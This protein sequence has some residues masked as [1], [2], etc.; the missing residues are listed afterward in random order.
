[1]R[2]F[3][4]HFWHSGKSDKARGAD[5]QWPRTRGRGSEGCQGELS[6]RSTGDSDQRCQPGSH[7]ETPHRRIIHLLHGKYLCSVTQLT[8]QKVFSC[9]LRVISWIK[10]LPTAC[11]PLNDT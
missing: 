9:G 5:V 4:N 1:M 10:P 2:W 8:S 11:D 6:A 7:S 3:M